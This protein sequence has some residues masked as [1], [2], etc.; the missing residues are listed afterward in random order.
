M[1]I[2]RY[3]NHHIFLLNMA[4][5]KKQVKDEVKKAV[6]KHEKEVDSQLDKLEKEVKPEE[7]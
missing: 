3:F 5:T 6:E 1:I 2:R 7:E 4:V